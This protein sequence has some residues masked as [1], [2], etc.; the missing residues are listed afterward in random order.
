MR[1]SNWYCV[2][3]KHGKE[4]IAAKELNKN[5]GIQ[6]FFPLL[7]RKIKTVN[8]TKVWLEALFPGYIFAKLSV[9][10]SY[11][12][13]SHTI[14]V[15]YIVRF[16]NR[17][18]TVPGEVI[19]ELLAATRKEPTIEAP[20]EIDAQIIFCSGPLEGFLGRVIHLVSSDRVR[21]L[22]ELLGRPACVDVS[23]NRV[24]PAAAW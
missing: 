2:K 1:E 21:V 14:G 7:S 12:S 4:Q 22:V 8:R 20:I 18:P 23:L 16:G 11:Y 15:S 9:V 13:V 19:E 3:C 24:I 5:L 10:D 6:V 17:F